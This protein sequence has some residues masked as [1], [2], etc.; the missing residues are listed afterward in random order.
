MNVHNTIDV[1]AYY[2]VSSTARSAPIEPVSTAHQNQPKPA[3]SA[4]LDYNQALETAR[5]LKPVNVHPKHVT[6]I[7][8]FLTVAHYS[9]ADTIIDIYA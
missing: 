7:D 2:R 1:G 8:T 6:A 4:P 3:K 9:G 5:E